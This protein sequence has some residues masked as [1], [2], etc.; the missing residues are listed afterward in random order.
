VSTI[1]P[2]FHVSR[3]G[4]YNTHAFYHAD[5]NG[6]VTC[7][8]NTNQEI[9]A[10]YTYDPFG[11]IL[12]ASGPLADANLYR[13][14]TKEY[15]A[16]SGAYYYGYRFYSPSLQRWLNR[17]PLGDVASLPLLTAAA[18]PS[19]D[20][21]SE[22]TQDE[23]TH[24]WIKIN[25]NLFG[26]LG[27]S[28]VGKVDASGLCEGLPAGS[29]PFNAPQTVKLATELAEEAGE[30]APK[31]ERIAEAAQKAKKAADAA[32]KAAEAAKRAKEIKKVRDAENALNKLKDIEKAQENVRKGKA[33]GKQIDRITGSEQRAKNL[34][35]DIA[36]DHTKC[37]E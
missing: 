24:T 7:L 1:N 20:S 22:M 16:N 36:R 17:D 34:L 25:A 15:H 21:D 29:D 5:G 11:G 2:T 8:I 28:P 26:G 33:V 37:D 14:S 18:A 9:V 6:N 4:R 13:F 32:R 10:K 3:S 23:F 12:S 19:A 31:A 27:N 30:I 35:K